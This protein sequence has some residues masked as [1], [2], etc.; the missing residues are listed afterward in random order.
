MDI[1][2]IEL[3]TDNIEETSNFYAVLLGFEKL[4]ADSKTISF[5]TGHSV[6]TFKASDNLKPKLY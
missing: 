1:L 4:H 3:L 6:L 5:K 2:E